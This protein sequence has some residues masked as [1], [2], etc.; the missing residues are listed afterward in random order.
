MT[1]YNYKNDQNISPLDY[2]V[3]EAYEEAGGTIESEEKAQEV[4]SCC[5]L[6]KGTI[7]DVAHQIIDEVCEI[8]EALECYFDYEAFAF[9][10]SFGD[11]YELSNFRTLYAP[12]R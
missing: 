12:V 9:N 1:E 7:L 11:Y 6:Y 2:E 4:A 5:I 8:D 3:L 10:L